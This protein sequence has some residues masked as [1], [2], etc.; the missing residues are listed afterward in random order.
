MFQC[1]YG[2]IC[3]QFQ[4]KLPLDK[5][6]KRPNSINENV[7]WVNNAAIESTLNFN[8]QSEDVAQFPAN[9]LP[10]ADNKDVTDGP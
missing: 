10:V 4:G 2:A 7:D 6:Q 1:H 8:G 9:F 3:E 5:H